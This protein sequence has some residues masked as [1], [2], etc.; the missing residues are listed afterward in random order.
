MRDWACSD[1]GV[2]GLTLYS[3]RDMVPAGV[4]GLLKPFWSEAVP[5]V[6]AASSWA[7]SRPLPLSEGIA[8]VVCGCW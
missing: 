1:G 7:V 8:K 6:C 2:L 4:S 3:V 5:F